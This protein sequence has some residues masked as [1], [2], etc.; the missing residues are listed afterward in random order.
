MTFMLEYSS[1]FSNPLVYVLVV[2]GENES[3][4]YF[5]KTVK[6]QFQGFFK[7]IL[8]KLNEFKAEEKKL[9][10]SFDIIINNLIQ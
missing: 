5:L 10:T 4:K 2:S 7:E 6:E 8:M 3:L 1:E 9:F